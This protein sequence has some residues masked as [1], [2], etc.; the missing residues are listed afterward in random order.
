MKCCLSHGFLNQPAGPS[1]HSRGPSAGQGLC[2]GLVHPID[3]VLCMVQTLSVHTAVAEQMAHVL[4]TTHV[5]LC[6]IC[7]FG[8]YDR[9]KSQVILTRSGLVCFAQTNLPE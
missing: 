9:W 7:P 1:R 4:T 6:S 8:Q 2:N 3:S 5:S